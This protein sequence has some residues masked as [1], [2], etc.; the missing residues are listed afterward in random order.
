MRYFLFSIPL[1]LFSFIPLKAQTAGENT[2]LDQIV[3]VVNGHTILESEVDQRLRRLLFQRQQR[4]MSVSFNEQM[5]YTILNNMV[6]SLVLLEHAKIDSITVSDEQVDRQIDVQI[7]QV[8]Q[9]V[10][11]E[12]LEERQGKSLL[13]IK[14][15]LREEYRRNAIIQEYR[16]QKISAIEITRPEV[17]E[18]FNDIPSDSL[19]EV[20]EQVAVSQ[21][22]IVPSPNEQAREEA[23]QLAKALRDSIINHGKSI[24]DLARKYSDGPAGNDGGELPLMPIDELVPPY[25]AAASALEPGEI[26][27][28]VETDFGFHVI[29]LNERRGDMI[30]TNHILITIDENSYNEDEAIEKLQAIRYT[31]ISNPDITFAE[32]AREKSEDPNTSS[33]GG[34][35]LQSQTGERLLQLESLNPSLYRIVLLLEEGE[36]S[37]PK[38]FNVGTANNS[39]PAYRIV[40]LDEQIPP[41]T[42]SLKTDYELIKNYALRE[43]RFRIIRQWISELK[44]EV[45]IDYKIPVPDSFKTTVT[46]MQ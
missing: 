32:M 4:G 29:R 27:K 28:V 37:E 14:A 17:I 35:I 8:V 39:R 31:V 10:G 2:S 25:A 24:E 22:V 40:R 6:E 46:A 23:F 1:L 11:R 45:Y 16:R 44:Q 9:Q 21:I 19:P 5:W 34:Q 33:Q 7:Q 12:T 15:D 43:K 20:P 36:I 41:H 42:A 13:Q 18:Y 38:P 30:D 3:A 26:S